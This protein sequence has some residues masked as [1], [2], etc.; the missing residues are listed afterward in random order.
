[1]SV[2]YDLIARDGRKLLMGGGCFGGLNNEG[3]LTNWSLRNGDHNNRV[4]VNLMEEFNNNLPQVML[5]FYPHVNH[6]GWTAEN[7]HTYWEDMQEIVDSLPW[8]RDMVIL[9]PAG[10][11]INFLTG[12]FPADKVMMAVF[13]LR[14]IAQMQNTANAYRA[15]R[16]QGLTPLQAAVAC[17]IMWLGNPGF[18][19]QRA[20]GTAYP[21]E[22]NFFNVYTFGR[23]S[24]RRFVRGEAEWQ[25][26]SWQELNGYRRDQWFWENDR[27]ITNMAGTQRHRILLDSLSISTGDAQLLD[28]DRLNQD[29]YL[30]NREADEAWFIARCLELQRIWPE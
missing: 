21:G 2:L 4:A 6:G 9:R 10:K 23:L 28:S 29:G 13:L 19:G 12:D 26:D 22:Y 24:L 14:N 25:L 17:S 3:V 8:M 1:M 11:F 20:A 5:R 18:G 27:T 30:E 15:A 16:N 7:S